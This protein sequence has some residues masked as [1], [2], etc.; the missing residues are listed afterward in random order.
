MSKLL[1]LKTV[2]NLTCLSRSQTYLLV[3][4]GKFPK[5]LKLSERSS[6]WVEQE[7]SDWINQRIEARNQQKGGI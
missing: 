4:Q 1:K 3:Q 6:A 7:V 5:P 2:L